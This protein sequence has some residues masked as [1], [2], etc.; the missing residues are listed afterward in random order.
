MLDAPTPC[1]LLV[2][3]ALVMTLDDAGT[4]IP[5]GAI[6]IAGTRILAIGS[7]AELTKTYAPARTIDARDRLALPG[8]VNVHNHSP[9][10]ITRGM[11]EDLG[12]APMYVPNIPQGH[13][14]SQEEAFLL[15]RLG[16]Y[17]ML[18]QGSTTIVDYYRFPEALAAAHAELG[19]RAIIGGR[20]H[21][22]DPEALAQGRHD[23]A[24]QIGRASIVENAELIARWNGHDGRIRCD[25]APHAPDTCSDALLKEVAGLAD[26]HGGNVHTHLA[27]SKSEVRIVRERTGKSPAEAL[28]AAGLL[29]ARTIAAHCIHLDAADVA[30]CGRAGMTVAH[31]PIG[32][33]KAGDVAP[34]LALRDA[35]ARIALCTDTMSGDMVEAMRWAVCM[36]RVRQG[37]EFV[38]DA[39][40]ALRWATRAGA[41]AIGMADE[42]GVLEPGRKADVILLDLTA[43]TLAPVVDGAGI[44]VW[45]ASGHDVDT[46]IVD[47]RVVLEGGLPTL[48]DGPA[49]VREAQKVAEGLWTRAGRRPVT[50]GG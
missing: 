33:A 28:D 26:A 18:R 30:L 42:I 22:V 10:M 21:D 31:S 24:T 48:T 13:R 45:S 38:L 1:D 32:N 17:E 14:L 15:S 41:E 12:F 44:L 6:A 27:Q 50:L 35:G 11:V 19:T 34:I 8:L 16:V 9:L 39:A 46:A 3:N 47:G 40:T 49:I 2:T 20:I 7:T 29:H 37:G 43:P 25:W 23:H 4:I 5:G 36:Q